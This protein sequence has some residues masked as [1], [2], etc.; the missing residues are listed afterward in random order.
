MKT[1][2]LGASGFIGSAFLRLNRVDDIEVVSRDK[3]LNFSGYK[4]HTGDIKDKTFLQYLANQ[5]FEKVINLAWEGL[6]VLSEHNNKLNLEMHLNTIKVFA[7]SG[8]KQ[9]DIA[10][11]CL[12]YGD[13]VGSAKEDSIGLNLS[14]FAR[15]KLLLLDFLQCQNISHRWFRIFYAYGPKQ[16]INSLL[17]SAYLKAK[18]GLNLELNNPN[19]SRD[20][21]YV[22]DVASA[23]KK[24]TSDSSA[25]GVFNIG[26]GVPTNITLMV[27]KVYEYFGLD[28]KVLKTDQNRSLIADT[29]R[30]KEVCGWNPEYPI[31]IGVDEYIKWADKAGLS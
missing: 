8:T 17:V 1:L 2:V 13:F 31:S 10:G 15:S 7:E 22:D 29:S 27:S 20:F 5:K 16:H 18:M 3:D 19:I 12:E 4:K 11:S 21:I 25:Q 9:F 28:F 23:I 14:D 26:S 6:P 24:L 30:I